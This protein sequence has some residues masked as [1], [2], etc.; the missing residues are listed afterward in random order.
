MS[1]EFHNERRPHR[2]RERGFIG[3]LILIGIGVVLLL[4][5]L[6]F[7]IP[8]NWWAV[9]LLVPAAVAFASAFATYN[10]E[11][12]LTAAATGSF[13]GG[14]ILVALTIIFLLQLKINWDLIGPVALI[15][16]G[17]G[18]LARHYQRS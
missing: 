4:Q 8:H 3:A 1:D 6:G 10:R 14:V 15:L 2:H 13:I 18:L 11:G 12:R 7:A 17:L 5:N 9:F 16:I